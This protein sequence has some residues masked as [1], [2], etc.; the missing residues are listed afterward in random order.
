MLYAWLKPGQ[1]NSH[2]AR[3]MFASVGLHGQIV[4]AMRSSSY[5]AIIAH[6]AFLVVLQASLGHA[7]NAESLAKSGAVAEICS[8]MDLHR[9]NLDVQRDGVQA[10]DCLACY[11]SVAQLSVASGAPSRVLRAMNGHLSCAQLQFFGCKA[12]QRLILRGGS[13]IAGIAA[14]AEAAKAAHPTDDGVRMY[15]VG[16]IKLVTPDAM[17]ATSDFKTTAADSE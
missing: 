1:P 7:G 10:L 16:L 15:S 4:G 14:A 17:W 5:D 8:A 11:D 3:G 6:Q 9:Q 13:P 2:R 12:L